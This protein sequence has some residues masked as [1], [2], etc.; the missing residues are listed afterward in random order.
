MGKRISLFH[1]SRKNMIGTSLAIRRMVKGTSFGLKPAIHHRRTSFT[2]LA[3]TNRHFMT[4]AA[5]PIIKEGGVAELQGFGAVPMQRQC[6]APLDSIAQFRARLREAAGLTDDE[7][8][9]PTGT[10]LDD[11]SEPHW[12]KDDQ[13]YELDEKRDQV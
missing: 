12:R 7:R 8:D 2:T 5:L 1:F 10:F 13:F 9:P 3:L 4:A 6:F 11:L